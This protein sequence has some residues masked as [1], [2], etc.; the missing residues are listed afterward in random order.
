MHS[1][2]THGLLH[3]SHTDVQLSA[4]LLVAKFLCLVAV[5]FLGSI[6]TTRSIC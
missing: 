2:R 5:E 4:L 1:N 3:F 6:D